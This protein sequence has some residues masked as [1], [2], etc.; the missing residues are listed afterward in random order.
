[1]S[2]VTIES[3]LEHCGLNE[4]DL[5]SQIEEAHFL[6][7]SSCLTKWKVLALK[8]PEL[9]GKWADI[10]INHSLEENRRLGFVE[11]LKQKLPLTATYGLLVRKLL[12]IERANDALSL[13]KHLKR[14]KFSGLVQT[15]FGKCSHHDTITSHVLGQHKWRASWPS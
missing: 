3:L 12:E 15:I 1:M 2:T 10:E 6:E 14:S 4:S 7:I 8:L 5:S 9:K 11:L 13:C